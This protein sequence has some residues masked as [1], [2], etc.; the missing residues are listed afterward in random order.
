MDKI[1]E[2]IDIFSPEV[3]APAMLDEQSAEQ[4]DIMKGKL[5]AHADL[6]TITKV[7]E[8]KGLGEM[9]SYLE[10]FDPYAENLNLYINIYDPRAEAVLG[11]KIKALEMLKT[12]VLAYIETQPI[13]INDNNATADGEDKAKEGEK[14]EATKSKVSKK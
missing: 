2:I 14:P 9:K 5:L 11:S 3:I 13:E 4:R 10:R 6:I 7:Y 1:K 8:D 12:N